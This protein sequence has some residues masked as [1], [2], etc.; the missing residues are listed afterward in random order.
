MRIVLPVRLG[1]VNVATADGEPLGATLAPEAGAWLAAVVGPMVGAVVPALLPHAATIIAATT[2]RTDTRG[3]VQ[4]PELAMLD[5]S[6][7]W[8]FRR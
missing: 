7:F 6:Q 5:P 1:G 3:R 4:W 8:D 2:A